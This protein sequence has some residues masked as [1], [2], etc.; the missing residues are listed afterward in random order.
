M[1]FAPLAICSFI[2][3]LSFVYGLSCEERLDEQVL[4]A[5]DEMNILKLLVARLAL[6]LLLETISTHKGKT[7]VEDQEVWGFMRMRIKV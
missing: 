2:I 7:A 3:H 1:D 4:L 5:I 6:L